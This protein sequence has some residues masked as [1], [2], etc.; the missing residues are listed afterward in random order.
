[1]PASVS[2]SCRPKT[3]GLGTMGHE[4]GRVGQVLD[5]VAAGGDVQKL[6]PAADAEQRQAATARLEQQRELEGVAALLLLAGLCVRGR[7][8]VQIDAEVGAADQQQAV[9]RVE[10]LAGLGRALGRRR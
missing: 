1:M 9:D 5:Q 4:V 3:P 8:A 7:R 6:H 2:T 10:H